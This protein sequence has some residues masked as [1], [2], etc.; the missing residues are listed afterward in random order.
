VKLVERYKKMYETY[1]G[2]GFP[3]SLADQLAGAIGAVFRSWNSERAIEYRNIH[4]IPHDWYTAVTVQAMVFGNMNEQ[5]C[6]G[7][8]FSRNGSTGDCQVMGE[9]LPNA[10]GEEV[11]SGSATPLDLKDL[12]K[13]NEKVEWELAQITTKLELAYRDMVDIE[14]TVQDGVL[15]LLQVRVGKRTALASFR[16]AYDLVQ[17]G[18]ITKEEA[19]KRVSGDMYMTLSKPVIAKSF[20]TPALAAGIPGSKGVAS[21]R[22]W[23]TSEKAKANP[24]GILVSKETTPDDFPGMAVSVG[25]LT[26]LGGA[27]SHAA[28]VARGMDKACVVGCTDMVVDAKGF[29]FGDHVVVE[30]DL[31][32]IDGQ[33]GRIWAGEVPMEGGVVPKFVAE[34]LDWGG[35]KAGMMKYVAGKD[36]LPDSGQVFISLTS[37]KTPEALVEFLE[38]LVVDHP[39]LHGVLSFADEISAFDDSQYLSMLGVKEVKAKMPP[40]MLT[41]FV[42]ADSFPIVQNWTVVGLGVE[43]ST[44]WTLHRKCQTLGQLLNCKHFYELSVDLQKFLKDQGLTEAQMLDLLASSGRK[45]KPIT[46]PVTRD[47]LAFAVFGS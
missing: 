2:H 37:L 25:I 42:L 21:G 5:S 13:W 23:M 17:S 24:G 3:Q 22:V 44:K 4:K 14:F 27:T 41:A 33:T 10:Q 30:G 6:S 47:A 28:V 8:L 18:V 45:L 29:K 43:T 1:V 26:Q 36:T 40:D 12:A 35:K 15:Y 38:T 11:V 39:E 16:I 34:M 19:L 7:V 20:T 9:F 46:K 32:T 31:I